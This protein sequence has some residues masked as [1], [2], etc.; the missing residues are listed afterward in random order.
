MP[1][2]VSETAGLHS[3]DRNNQNQIIMYTRWFIDLAKMQE[4]QPSVFSFPCALFNLL[5]SQ[6]NQLNPSLIKD[7]SPLENGEKNEEIHQEKDNN[8]EKRNDESNE[9]DD[10][11][12]D[13][14]E[15]D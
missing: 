4:D 14:S 9:N 3:G 15:N 12:N 6:Y 11:E 13:D 1:R 7:M 2:S 5:D 8:D 10:S